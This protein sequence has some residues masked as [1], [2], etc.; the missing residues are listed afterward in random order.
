MRKRGKKFLTICACQIKWITHPLHITV[1]GF[2]LML[3]T[4]QTFQEGILEPYSMCSSG[5]VTVQHY[6]IIARQITSGFTITYC[7]INPASL[8][9]TCFDWSLRDQLF[10]CETLQSALYLKV[11]GALAT[12]P[13]IGRDKL[14]RSK[15]H[16]EY[17]ACNGDTTPNT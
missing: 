8:Q 14:L 17:S 6:V 16:R 12:H 11:D 2:C 10:F 7:T 3:D 9:K 4:E 13:H 15:P 1:T 5:S